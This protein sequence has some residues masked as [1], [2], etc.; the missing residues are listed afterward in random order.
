MLRRGAEKRGVW[1]REQQ[2]YRGRGEKLRRLGEGERA[3]MV[4]ELEWPIMAH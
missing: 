4:A 1:A 2:I 3:Q